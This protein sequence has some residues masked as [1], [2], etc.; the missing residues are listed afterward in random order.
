M[1]RIL[2][3]TIQ[4]RGEPKRIRVDNG[5]EFISSKLSLWCEE[6]RINL[7]FIQPGKPS[8]NA[9]IER[10]NRRFRKD[11]LDAYL[12]ETLGQVQT[13]LTSGCMTITMNVRT[14][15]WNG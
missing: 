5:P 2:E 15:R 11:I 14:M 8:Q 7:Q 1:V 4:W 9:Y 10:F 12:F 3:H 6:H 13:W